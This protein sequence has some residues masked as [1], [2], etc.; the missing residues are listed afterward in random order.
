MKVSC[1]WAGGWPVQPQVLVAIQDLPRG[2]TTQ[3]AFLPFSEPNLY[4]EKKHGAGGSFCRANWGSHEY[5]SVAF[6]KNGSP[7]VEIIQ[8]FMVFCKHQLSGI[9]LSFL[10][11]F[12][13]RQRA[14]SW[15]ICSSQLFA[16]F[17]F[18]FALLLPGR[19]CE[20]PRTTPALKSGD[21]Q[22]IFCWKKNVFL[23][24]FKCLWR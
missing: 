13:S 20:A 23:F 21:V 10:G 17:L 6:F 3:Q 14:S 2:N 9:W 22:L 24:L 8:P 16:Y 19:V 15:R 12:S 5:T 1:K 18:G 7:P 11:N 4:W